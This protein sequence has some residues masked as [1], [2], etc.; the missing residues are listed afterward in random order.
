MSRVLEKLTDGFNLIEGPVWDSSLGLV[1]SDSVAGGV[2]ALSEAGEVTEV[3]KHRKGIGGISKHCANGLIVSGRNIAFKP[4][5]GGDTHTLLERDLSAGI[6]GFNDITTDRLGRIYAGSLG[7][8][9]VGAAGGAAAGKLFLINLDGQVTEVASDVRL[10]NGLAFSPDGQTLYHSDSLRRTV[11]KYSVKSDGS[12]GEK[13]PFARVRKGGPDGLV[14]AADG[15]VW[16]AL[17][18]GGHGVSV[19]AQD[20]VETEFIEIP[21][22]L[23]TSLCFGGDDLKT[24]YIVSGSE[25]TSSDTAGAVYRLRVDVAGVPVSDAA[26]QLKQVSEKERS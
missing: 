2:F 9:P 26:V 14:V 17:A 4:L 15:S 18:G 8:G 10:N 23:C 7:P 13:E 21:E 24:L 6:T 3:F 20:G 5:D 19:F 22:P 16:V 25:G 12:V 11:F 1:F